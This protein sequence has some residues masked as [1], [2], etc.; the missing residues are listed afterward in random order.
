MT[1][2]REMELRQRGER[3]AR[4]LHEFVKRELDDREAVL[5]VLLGAFDYLDRRTVMGRRPDGTWPEAPVSPTSNP[6]EPDHLN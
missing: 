6:D 5:Q 4:E 3:L 1:N 2:P